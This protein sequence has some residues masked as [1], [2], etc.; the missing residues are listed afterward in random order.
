MNVPLNLPPVTPN[1]L[2][3]GLQYRVEA[4]EETVANMQT[5]LFALGARLGLTPFEVC[6]LV[7]NA[8]KE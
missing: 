7:N 2:I 4:I 1:G 3:Q 5:V 8:P 6:T